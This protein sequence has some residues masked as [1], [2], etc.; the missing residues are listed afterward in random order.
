MK[1]K[2]FTFLSAAVLL[3]C[4]IL[5]A[6]AAKAECQPCRMQCLWYWCAP[7]ACVCRISSSMPG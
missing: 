1:R 2:I 7:S 4:T 6:S 5:P 3:V